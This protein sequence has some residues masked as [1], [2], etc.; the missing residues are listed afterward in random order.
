MLVELIC[1]YSCVSGLFK[2][3]VVV[4]EIYSKFELIIGNFAIFLLWELVSQSWDEFRVDLHTEGFYL[5]NCG[6]KICESVYGEFLHLLVPCLII[7]F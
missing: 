4:S 6:F 3:S 5:F 2:I 1:I 7:F